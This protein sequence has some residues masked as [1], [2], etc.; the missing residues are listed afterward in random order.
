MLFIFSLEMRVIA[1]FVG[2]GQFQP[3]AFKCIDPTASHFVS[4]TASKRKTYSLTRL[5]F[6]PERQP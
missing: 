5:S 1:E 3:R 2:I 6:L 4:C